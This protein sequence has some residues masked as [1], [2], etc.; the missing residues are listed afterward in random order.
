[1]SVVS[2]LKS[3]NE[4]FLKYKELYVATL[5][6]DITLFFIHTKGRTDFRVT[7]SSYYKRVY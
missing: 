2:K 6:T 7:T 3:S 4:I 5:V 1:M